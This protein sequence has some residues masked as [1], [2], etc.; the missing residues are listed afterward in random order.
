MG[1]SFL[2]LRLRRSS[3]VG[4]GAFLPILAAVSITLHGYYY[5]SRSSSMVKKDSHHATTGVPLVPL[6][7]GT[8]A[9]VVDMKF[10][11]T[12]MSPP[13]SVAS[14]SADRTATSSRSGT[15]TS[16]NDNVLDRVVRMLFNSDDADAYTRK[17]PGNRFRFYVYENLHPELTWQNVS[18]CIFERHRQYTSR[19]TNSEPSNCDWGGTVCTETSPRSKVY[20]KRRFNRNGDVVLAKLFSEYE[21]EMRTRDP[22]KADLFVV[23]YP[24][25][26]HCECRHRNYKCWKNIPKQE[27][28]EKL[29]PRLTYWD[30]ETTAHKHLFLMSNFVDMHWTYLGNS[31][32][33]TTIGPSRCAFRTNST[34]A[35]DTRAGT[36]CNKLVIPYA[37]LNRE[38][39]PDIVGNISNNSIIK[40]LD[41]REYAVSAFMST[42]LNGNARDRKA[43]LAAFENVTALGDGKRRK[44][45]SVHVSGLSGRGRTI[46]GESSVQAQYR[47][48]IFCPVLRGDEPPQKRLF[49]VL[50]AGCIPVVLEHEVSEDGTDF[51]SHFAPNAPSTRT[52]YPWA[53][54]HPTGMGLE[55]SDLVIAIKASECGRDGTTSCFPR[56]LEELLSTEDLYESVVRKKHQ[57]VRTYASLFSYGM[58]D[59]AFKYPDAVASLL[60]HARHFVSIED[61]FR[62]RKK[63]PTR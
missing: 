3:T 6:L 25:A 44:R 36:N 63:S 35:A 60:V 55:W 42:N 23:P 43:F 10:K 32:L 31:K 49:D 59:N 21:G 34:D 27:L 26:G 61:D 46:R 4:V 38:A 11:E 53:K 14:S 29:T 13:T 8:D 19:P 7:S 18:K 50:L 28:D 20:S 17:N 62:K 12:N 5:V 41:D 58:E 48:T 16:T 39:Q 52:T 45:W 2:L 47:N 9:D 24:S 33:T 22:L 57:N 30:D 40:P 37:N 1:L 15:R 54:Q 56:V 51:P